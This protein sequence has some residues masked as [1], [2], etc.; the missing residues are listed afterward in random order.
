MK[1][2]DMSDGE[3]FSLPTVL[4]LGPWSTG[5]STLVNYILGIE[6]SSFSLISE[7]QEY[8]MAGFEDHL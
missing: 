6:N 4:L 2:H 8:Y 3:I 5:K 7:M 1:Q